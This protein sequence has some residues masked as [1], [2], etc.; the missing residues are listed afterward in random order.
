MLFSAVELDVI[1][2]G[3]VGSDSVL[4][5]ASSGHLKKCNIWLHFSDVDPVAEF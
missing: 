1:L 4:D 5:S 3:S 2:Q